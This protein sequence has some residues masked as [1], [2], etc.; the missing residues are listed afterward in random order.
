MQPRDHAPTLKKRLDS[1]EP[2]LTLGGPSVRASVVRKCLLEAKLASVE[3]LLLLHTKG[4]DW[5]AGEE[6][7]SGAADV[8]A[9][10]CV[11]G[12]AAEH[13]ELERRYRTRTLCEISQ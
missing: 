9:R 12:A 1:R 4:D 2:E 10:V 11:C 8:G 13:L 7:C 5:D 3:M 6:T